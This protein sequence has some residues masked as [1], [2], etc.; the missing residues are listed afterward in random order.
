MRTIKVLCILMVIL[1]M[2]VYS[3][4][5]TLYETGFETVDGF[6]DGNSI[7]GID[8]W[9]VVD[10]ATTEDTNAL[11][12]DLALELIWTG[13]YA[14]AYHDFTAS[15]IVSIEFL[16]HPVN[17]TK[18]FGWHIKDGTGLRAVSAWFDGGKFK[19]YNGGTLT[20]ISSAISIN[21]TYDIKIEINATAGIH[22]YKIYLNSVLKADGFDFR[23]STADTLSKM[24]LFRGTGLGVGVVDDLVITDALLALPVEI[25]SQPVS[26]LLDSGGVNAQFVITAIN[27][28][29]YQWYKDDAAISTSDANFAGADSNTLTVYDVNQAEGDTGIYYCN[30][31]NAN[32]SIDSDA[33]ALA[34]KDLVAHYKFDEGSGSTAADSSNYDNDVNV[35]GASFVAVGSVDGESL[36][37]DPNDECVL[38]N[39]ASDI[40]ILGLPY[41]IEAWINLDEDVDNAG[42]SIEQM[43]VSYG[44]DELLEFYIF[45][46]AGS[47][48]SYDYSGIR[49]AWDTGGTL[50]ADV[51]AAHIDT[52]GNWVH[53]ATTFDG[54]T[55]VTY[56]NG[57][58]INAAQPSGIYDTDNAD[59]FK[60]GGGD[61]AG[62]IDDI[63]IYNYA[64]TATQ[65]ADAVYAVT[66][67]PVCLEALGY[68]DRYEGGEDLNYDCKIDFVDFANFAE[69]WM[70]DNLYTP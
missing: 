9:T 2:G 35:I 55:R 49:M 64:R 7:A 4:A 3:Q 1:A 45:D 62:I 8:G 57:Q 68:G 67:E 14:R 12:G 36:S 50:T 58:K 52:I 53:Y 21:T 25:T 47:H 34:I 42:T 51:Y 27:T 63:R 26:Q 13:S 70:D 17:S 5:A 48:S 24:E 56:V 15:N 39:A 31:S 37:F 23:D 18:M 41:T 11:S 30:A 69:N 22:T 66:G 43:I 20:T 38:L 29:A 16:A 28:T 6:S 65:V 40:P 19:A 60:I 32:F 54:T 10:Y 59:D 44:G 46:V 33:A 61:T